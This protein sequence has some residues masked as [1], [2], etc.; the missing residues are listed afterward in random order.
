MQKILVLMSKNV[1]DTNKALRVVMVLLYAKRRPQS[2]SDLCI[3]RTKF[4]LIES[5][6]FLL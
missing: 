1:A 6:L 3:K 4:L 5:I 2:L